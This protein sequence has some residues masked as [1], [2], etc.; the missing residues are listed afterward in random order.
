MLAK[1]I[2]RAPSASVPDHELL[3]FCYRATPKHPENR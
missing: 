2:E 3:P 1:H